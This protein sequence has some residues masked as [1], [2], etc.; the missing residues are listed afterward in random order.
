MLV[1][2][3]AI[4]GVELFGQGEREDYE[5]RYAAGGPDNRAIEDLQRKLDQVPYKAPAGKRG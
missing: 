2:V 4:V 3:A 1:A 5:A